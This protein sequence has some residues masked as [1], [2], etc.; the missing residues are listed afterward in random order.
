MHLHHVLVNQI[1]LS[2]TPW[3]ATWTCWASLNGHSNI[4]VFNVITTRSLGVG[5]HDVL[6]LREKKTIPAYQQWVIN[7]LCWRLSW[8]SS[9]Q[10]GCWI[11]TLRK[12]PAKYVESLLYACYA[13]ILLA[14]SPIT[15]I[16]VMGLPQS[17]RLSEHVCSIKRVLEC[18]PVNF[19]T[20][21]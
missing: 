7:N 15:N 2:L 11:F 20:F 4:A 21:A 5:H 17:V 12:M 16:P 19:C 10:L 1:N 8:N 14:T 18:K 9:Q 6:R 13:C 3:M